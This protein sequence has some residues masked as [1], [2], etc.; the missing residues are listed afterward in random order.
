[1]GGATNDVGVILSTL[2]MEVS[3]VLVADPAGGTTPVART[4][5]NTDTLTTNA[6]VADSTT[7]A[8]LS[9]LADRKLKKIKFQGISVESFYEG[10]VMLIRFE[11][12]AVGASNADVLVWAMEVN[13]VRWTHGEKL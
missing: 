12:D 4:V 2:P 13:A 11:L 7:G 1:V 10:D 5:A 3:E 6:G 9:A 8:A